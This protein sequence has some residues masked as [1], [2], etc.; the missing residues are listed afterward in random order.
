[1]IG[2][3][4]LPKICLYRH[5]KLVTTEYESLLRVRKRISSPGRVGIKR[6]RGSAVLIFIRTT[7]TITMY[8][9][10]QIFAQGNKIIHDRNSWRAMGNAPTPAIIEI[11]TR[12]PF[13][14]LPINSK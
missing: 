6:L 5:L 9:I 10:E 8:A 13:N 7:S 11:N 14:Y 4:F 2:L 12:V 1:M 3:V